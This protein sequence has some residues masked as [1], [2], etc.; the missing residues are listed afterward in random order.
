MLWTLVY[1][2]MTQGGTG[3]LQTDTWATGLTFAT[4]QECLEAADKAAPG[5]TRGKSTYVGPSGGI[6]GPNPNAITVQPVCFPAA[7]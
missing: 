7:R 2:L 5:L 6:G 4:Q 1:I 3:T